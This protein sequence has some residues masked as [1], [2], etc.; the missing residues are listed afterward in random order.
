MF[1]DL[2]KG[3]FVID[4]VADPHALAAMQAYADACGATVPELAGAL[5]RTLGITSDLPAGIDSAWRWLHLAQSYAQTQP[6]LFEAG[7]EP[8]SYRATVGS[9]AVQLRGAAN[10]IKRRLGRK[11]WRRT[12]L[13]T[14][15]R[16]SVISLTTQFTTEAHR[17][18][19]ACQA[20]R[21]KASG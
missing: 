14:R 8:D 3:K 15:S 16:E 17:V 2:G 9:T 18:L 12:G 4:T 1:V 19:S 11:P 13:R 5:R 10:R 21:L 6:Q 20:S 7:M